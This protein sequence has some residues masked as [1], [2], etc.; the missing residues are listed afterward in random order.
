MTPAEGNRTW[1]MVSWD[2]GSSL[3]LCHSVLPV[4]RQNFPGT[5]YVLAPPLVRFRPRV[6]GVL[7]WTNDPF[8][9]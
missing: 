9:R 6:F 5:F 1:F 2:S 7:I 4:L 3:P 8:Q